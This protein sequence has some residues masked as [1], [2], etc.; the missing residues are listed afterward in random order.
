MAATFLGD[1]LTILTYPILLITNEV[2]VIDSVLCLLYIGTYQP[3]SEALAI[4]SL[5]VSFL[6]RVGKAAR[7]SVSESE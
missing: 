4:T 2:S 6:S 1:R 5:S 7:A 3:S